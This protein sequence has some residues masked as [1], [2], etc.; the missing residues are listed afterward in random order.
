VAGAVLL[1]VAGRFYLADTQAGTAQAVPDPAALAR[2][3]HRPHGPPVHA[4]DDGAAEA[5]AGAGAGVPRASL[6]EL[7]RARAI[8]PFPAFSQE[9]ATLLSRARERLAQQLAAPVETLIAL[10]R[11]EERVERALSRELGASDQWIAAPSGSL[12]EYGSEWERFRGALRDHHARLGERVE[13]AAERAVPNL[14][15]LVGAR[16]AGR[17]VAAA[18]GLEPLGRM[19]GSRL[20]MLGTR[21]PRGGDRGPKYGVI[22]LAVHAAEVPIDRRGAYARSLANLAA[23]AARAD[24]TTRAPVAASLMERRDRRLTQLR[25]TRRGP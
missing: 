22:A 16:V 15:A 13:R 21:R 14:S 25:R 10:A 7:R 6:A 19:S 23:I 12:A 8:V 3:G 4:G 5:L 1:H 9:R 20:Q 24:A 11:E 17:L 2:S 18:G